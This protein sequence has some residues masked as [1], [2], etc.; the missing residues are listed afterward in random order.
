MVWPTTEKISKKCIEN[1]VHI[2]IYI[3]YPHK[4]HRVPDSDAYWCV[5]KYVFNYHWNSFLWADKQSSALPR[6]DNKGLWFAG[7]V[8]WTIPNGNQT[9]TCSD[10]QFVLMSQ[11]NALWK[12]NEVGQ[13]MNF[14]EGW[15]WKMCHTILIADSYWASRLSSPF[16]WASLADRAIQEPGAKFAGGDP[17]IRTRMPGLILGGAQHCFQGLWPY[18]AIL[19]HM[20]PIFQESPRPINDL[21]SG[22]GLQCF[23]GAWNLVRHHVNVVW[24]APLQLAFFLIFFLHWMTCSCTIGGFCTCSSWPRPCA[25]WRTCLSAKSW[26]VAATLPCGWRPGLGAEA[27]TF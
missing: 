12:L 21:R 2:Y 16:V 13:F 26:P 24:G 7:Y 1:V 8:A 27:L 14:F 22:F 20:D 4:T 5:T 18:C 3:C 11:L 15:T 9:I 10:E 23:L 25:G 17:Q 19:V 6:E